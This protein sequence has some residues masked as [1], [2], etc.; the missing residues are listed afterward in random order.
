[1]G[2]NWKKNP[3]FQGYLYLGH[4]TAHHSNCSKTQCLHPSISKWRNSAFLDTKTRKAV[5]KHYCLTLLIAK[6][7]DNHD[8]KYTISIK[9]TR[10]SHTGSLAMKFV[11]LTHPARW[12]HCTLLSGHRRGFNGAEEDRL[13]DLN[14]CQQETVCAT[15]RPPLFPSIPSSPACC[16]DGWSLW[17]HYGVSSGTLQTNTGRDVKKQPT[18]NPKLKMYA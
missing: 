8:L 6:D 3:T 17:W 18:K 1:M 10:K 4:C 9:N 14:T 13:R 7:M 12:L 15:D 16:S 11:Q 2:A 5:V